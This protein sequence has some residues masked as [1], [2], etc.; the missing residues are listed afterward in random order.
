MGDL[1]ADVLIS[2]L[3]DLVTAAVLHLS[4][5]PHDS[6]LVPDAVKGVMFAQLC[7]C[8]LMLTKSL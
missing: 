5:V 2:G 4:K 3:A 6:T 8:S 1:A 7:L